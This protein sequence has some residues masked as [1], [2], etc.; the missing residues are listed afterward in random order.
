MIR[1]EI[2]HYDAESKNRNTST[3]YREESSNLLSKLQQ[4]GTQLQPMEY[5]KWLQKYG[6]FTMVYETKNITLYTLD[7]TKKI[8]FK[9]ENTPFYIVHF[10]FL[11]FFSLNLS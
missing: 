1:I 5:T 3:A 10:L 4:W 11:F 9:Q 7:S 8:L 6:I 2:A